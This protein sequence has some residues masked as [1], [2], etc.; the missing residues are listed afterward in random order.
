MIRSVSEL[1]KFN[2]YQLALMLREYGCDPD[3]A[4]IAAWWV[5]HNKPPRNWS[6]HIQTTL[7]KMIKFRIAKKRFPKFDDDVFKWIMKTYEL[8]KINSKKISLI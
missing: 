5:T 6:K 4:A 7:E 8:N 1:R 2:S 3:V